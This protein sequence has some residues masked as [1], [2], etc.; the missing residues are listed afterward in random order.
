M[1]GKL[2]GGLMC[3]KWHAAPNLQPVGDISNLQKVTTEGATTL[4]M[5]GDT[6]VGLGGWM[7]YPPPCE[8]MMFELSAAGAVCCT[9]GITAG[10]A[11][12]TALIVSVGTVASL[13]RDA[14]S[15]V[16]CVLNT[17]SIQLSLVHVSTPLLFL[18]HSQPCLKPLQQGQFLHSGNQNSPA[19]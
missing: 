3:L 14:S 2:L 8:M 4:G 1:G 7:I 19:N 11:S 9:A 10:D 13:L 12:A 16:T 15:S 6:A 5:I 18:Q 17:P